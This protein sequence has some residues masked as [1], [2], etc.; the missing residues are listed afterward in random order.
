MARKRINEKT[1]REVRVSYEN[2]VPKRKIAEKFSISL[3][4]VNRIIKEQSPAE[5]AEAQPQKRKDEEMKRKIAHI[6]RRI[7]E[8]E[9]KI[10]Q[11]EIKKKRASFKMFP[12]FSGIR[13][14]K[15]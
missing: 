1:R 4:S 12:A 8:L 15:R 2:G 13:G 7:S 10:L 11:L 9:E 6:E 5:T 14:Q 3:T